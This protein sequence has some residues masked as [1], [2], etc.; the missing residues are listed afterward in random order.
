MTMNE[1]KMVQIW[2]YDKIKNDASVLFFTFPTVQ[3]IYF[4]L[5]LDIFC[6]NIYRLR[7]FDLCFGPRKNNGSKSKIVKKVI[8]FTI[9]P[10]TAFLTYLHVFTFK[11][12]PISL[13][14]HPW[15][16][17]LP[18]RPG[19]FAARVLLVWTS[20]L[21]HVEQRIRISSP[22]KPA[23]KLRLLAAAKPRPTAEI[24][25]LGGRRSRPPRSKNCRKLRAAYFRQF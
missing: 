25:D 3:C 7:F 5:V 21:V 24:F 9:Q 17:Q 13:Y 4:E 20:E 22:A 1:H 15:G 19:R 16:P 14:P 11:N 23:M 2:G 10:N 6:N 8:N 18:P 12:T